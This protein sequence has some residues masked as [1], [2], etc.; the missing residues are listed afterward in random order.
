LQEVYGSTGGKVPYSIE[1]HA[2]PARFALSRFDEDDHLDE[3]SPIPTTLDGFVYFSSMGSGGHFF[4]TA[5]EAKR[6][7]DAQ[8]WGPVKWE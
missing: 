1:I 6:W 5:G 2:R 8:S 3:A 7:V 4:L